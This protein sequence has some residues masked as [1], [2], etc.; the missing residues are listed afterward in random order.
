MAALVNII[1]D[2]L[3]DW[4]RIATRYDE[5]SKGVRGLVLAGCIRVSNRIV[6]RGRDTYF[7][8][9]LCS[10]QACSPARRPLSARYPTAATVRNSNAW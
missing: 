10:T 7:A 9:S 5:V 1:A 2:L 8:R 3:M 6:R 4:R